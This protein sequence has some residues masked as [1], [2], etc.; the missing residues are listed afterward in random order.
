MFAHPLTERLAAFVRDAVRKGVAP[1]PH[2]LRW[3]R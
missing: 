1:F 3:V 2:M